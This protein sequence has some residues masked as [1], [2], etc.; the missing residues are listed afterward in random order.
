MVQVHSLSHNVHTQQGQLSLTSQ[1]APNDDTKWLWEIRHFSPISGSCMC[2]LN[3]S[4]KWMPCGHY[5]WNMK[6]MKSHWSGP[7][8]AG[9]RES[10]QWSVRM[11]LNLPVQFTSENLKKGEK[12][13]PVSKARKLILICNFATLRLKGLGQV[14]ASQE[15]AQ[16]WHQ[17]DGTHFV[18]QIQKM[19]WHYQVFEQLPLKKWGGAQKGHTLLL[20][21]QIWNDAHEWLMAQPASEITP[22]GFQTALNST[23]LPNISITLKQLLSIRTA[24]QW[25]L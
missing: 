8:F 20:N 22:L 9:R 17:G 21:E 3:I 6:C 19:A 12:T 7:R 5:V 24:H 18:C 13:L 23:I 25:L 14:Q 10:H 1:H 16:Q 4:W 2:H 15:I 11:L